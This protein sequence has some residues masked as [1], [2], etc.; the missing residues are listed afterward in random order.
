MSTNPTHFDDVLALAPEIV[1]ALAAF[2]VLVAGI[3][4]GVRSSKHAGWIVLAGLGTAAAYASIP[5]QMRKRV[6]GD[7]IATISGRE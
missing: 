6:S 4:F 3:L 7:Q 1:L 5:N 2:A